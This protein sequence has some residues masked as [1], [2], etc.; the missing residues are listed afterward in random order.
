MP[1]SH[2]KIP[3]SVT[4]DH[5]LVPAPLYCTWSTSQDGT[6]LASI[7]LGTVLL[8]RRTSQPAM[9][10]F[11]P[12]SSLGPCRRPCRHC[13][14]L[15]GCAPVA[16]TRTRFESRRLDARAL[17]C[18]HTYWQGRQAQQTVRD[19]ASVLLNAAKAHI[20]VRHAHARAC[21]ADTVHAWLVD[22]R[23]RTRLRLHPHRWARSVVTSNR[24]GGSLPASLSALTEL[25]IMCA[26]GPPPPGAPW[27]ST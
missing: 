12:S 27:M 25:K 7:G 6:Q 4:P 5:W 26:A 2:T 16:A 10:E 23:T 15:S 3:R 19:G 20:S 21:V 24:I 17:P 1:A 13:P 22:S 18:G 11:S 8:C 14:T 9:A